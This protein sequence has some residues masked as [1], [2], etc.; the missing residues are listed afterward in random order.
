MR[1]IK[2]KGRKRR[3]RGKSRAKNGGKKEKAK[4]R[5]KKKNEVVD[6]SMM[7]ALNDEEEGLP[8]DGDVSIQIHKRKKGKKSGKS[9]KVHHKI[10]QD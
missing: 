5:K 7:N 4:Q 1:R 6:N 9:N 8:R 10:K 2:G 3:R